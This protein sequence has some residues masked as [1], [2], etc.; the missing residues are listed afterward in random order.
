MIPVRCRQLVLGLLVISGGYALTVLSGCA[1]PEPDVDGDGADT[2]AVY[3]LTFPEPVFSESGRALDTLF[4]V[5]LDDDGRREY[6][7][8]SLQRERLTAPDSRADLV[9]IY[10]YDTASRSWA[11]VLTDSVLWSSSYELRELT[12]DRAPEV[13]V[14]VFAGGNDP[15]ASR[16]M[17]V[18][19][20]HGGTIRTLLTLDEGDPQLEMIGG[21]GRPVVVQHAL[22][23]PPMVPHVQAVPYVSDVLA[24]TGTG[25]ESVRSRHAEYFREEADMHLKAYGESLKDAVVEEPELIGENGLA[26]VDV[27]NVDLF[28]SAAGTV[29]SLDQA[30]QS[31]ALRS[32]WNREADTLR[33]L[34]PEE[35]FDQLEE[36]Y[37]ERIMR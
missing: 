24:F 28:I 37:A 19:S 6:V 21:E 13:I 2:A 7:V 34:L 35:Q 29:I 32:F 22:I 33:A 17:R 25:F 1:E 36:L 15:V 16:G 18:Y 31:E 10:R 5:D 27:P 30:G 20:G 26:D 4:A 8:T 23:W 11:V 9:E 12:G 14:E 3:D